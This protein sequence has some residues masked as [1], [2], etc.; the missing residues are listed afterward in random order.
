MGARIRFTAFADY[1]A[2]QFPAHRYPSIADIAGGAGYLQN[3]LLLHG[4]QVTTY[5]PKLGRGVDGIRQ[6]VTMQTDVSAHDVLVG[7]HPDGATDVIVALAAQYRKPFVI[8]P[9]CIIPTVTCYVG[10]YE[11]WMVHLTAWATGKGFEVQQDMLKMHGM[12]QVI[13]GR[14]SDNSR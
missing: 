10:S 1:L 14:I 7:M 9:C 2:K 11:G 8:V 12:N 5:D 13:V 4:Y 3:D 6:R